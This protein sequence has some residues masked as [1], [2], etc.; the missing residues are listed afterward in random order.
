MA[1]LRK[2]IIWGHLRLFPYQHTRH[3]LKLPR[4]AIYT[5]HEGSKINIE[6]TDDS[7]LIV[8]QEGPSRQS[9]KTQPK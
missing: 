8:F 9:A 5:P 1:I 7:L 2:L 6:S 3:D 4:N